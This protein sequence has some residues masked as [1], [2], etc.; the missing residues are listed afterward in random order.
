[1]VGFLSAQ[2]AEL[3]SKNITVAFLQGLKETGCVEGQNVAGP[4]YPANLCDAQIAR[5]LEVLVRHDRVSVCRKK[6][7]ATASATEL[8]RRA[9][10]AEESAGRKRPV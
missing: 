8:K 7:L 6:E 9:E 5:P 3:D 1:L 10:A 4:H 2:S